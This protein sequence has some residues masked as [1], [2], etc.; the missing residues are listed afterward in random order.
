MASASHRAGCLHYR[1]CSAPRRLRA[2]RVV[3]RAAFVSGLRWRY[4][5]PRATRVSLTRGCSAR[6]ASALHAA[7]AQR[8]VPQVVQLSSTHFPPL[9]DYELLNHRAVGWWVE[10]VG[11]RV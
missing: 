5:A 4:N 8:L 6:R 1:L 11:V 2:F 10:G 7:V 3:S 9:D